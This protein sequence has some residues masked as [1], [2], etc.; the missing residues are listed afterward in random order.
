MMPP[1]P[2]ITCKTVQLH[3]NSAV[4]RPEV[5]PK[6]TTGISLVLIGLLWQ[7]D[8]GHDEKEG[9]Q[10]LIHTVEDRAAEMCKINFLIVIYVLTHSD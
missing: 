4:S 6:V 5:D 1:T 9:M 3:A 2:S 10:R 7:R 8:R